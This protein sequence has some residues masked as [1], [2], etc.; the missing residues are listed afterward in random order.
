MRLDFFVA[1][2][3][4]ENGRPYAAQMRNRGRSHA[5]APLLCRRTGRHCSVG[6]N[7][8]AANLTY[9]PHIR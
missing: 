4:G 2:L 7:C 6:G 3:D 8:A 5:L 9:L 1:N